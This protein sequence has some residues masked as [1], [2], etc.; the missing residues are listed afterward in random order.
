MKKVYLGVTA[1]AAVAAAV[2][3]WAAQTSE[4]LELV[5]TVQVP[6][7]KRFGFDISA[8]GNG[9]FYLADQA[10]ATLD[11]IDAKALMLTAQIQGN[12]AGVAGGDH[13]RSGPAGVT[14]LPGTSLVYVGD[15]NAV[16]VIDVAAGKLVKTIPVSASGFRADEGCLDP[17]HHLAMF[18]SGAEKPP[19]VTFIDTSTHTPVGK[20]SL[21]DATGL[22]ACVY[23]EAHARFM[24]NNDGTKA[25]PTGEVDLIPVASVQVGQPAVSEVFPLKD[26]DGPTGLALG[27]GNDALVACDPDQGGKQQSLIIDRSDGKT[28][29]TLP[30][31]GTDQA[32]YDPVSN[33]YFLAAGHHSNDNISQVG[34]KDA[35]FD[36]ALGVIDAGTRTL[37]AV[38]PTGNGSHSVAVDGES[39]RVFVPYGAGSPR[40]PG[41][42]VS[43][44]ETR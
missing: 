40:F 38:V 23:D 30:F 15:V 11:V 18:S 21:P 22:E 43:V 14:P 26:C 9:N 24:M 1:F 28:L 44:F 25:N 17:Q 5:T 33:R 37:V 10:N 12:F 27:P 31:G 2:C 34:K 8:A 39:H 41:Q 29:A 3:A 36:P 35:R 32:V 13:D 42:G 16:K 19:F 7:P 4:P 20:L 6:S